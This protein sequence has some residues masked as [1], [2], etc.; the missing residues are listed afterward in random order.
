MTKILSYKYINLLGRILIGIFAI[1]I[2]VV[3]LQ[4]ELI[5]TVIENSLHVQFELLFFTFILLFLNWGIEAFKWSYAIRP[6]QKINFITAF[7]LTITGI[8]IGLITPNRLGEIPGRAILLNNKKKLKDLV[9]KTSVGSFSQL[10]VTFLFGTIATF[11]TLHFFQF[12]ISSNYVYAF[13]IVFTLLLL[14]A[15][16]YNQTIKKILYRIPFFKRTKL[17]KAL[18]S[19]TFNELV[20]IL[21]LSS[22]RYIVFAIQYYFVLLALGIEFRTFSELLLIPFCF[23]ITSTI[24]TILISEIGVRGSVALFVFGAISDHT[25]SI[26]TASILLWLINIA[27]PALF[28]LFFIN[29]L[30]IVGEG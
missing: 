19:F 27:L 17:L 23:L 2:I 14:L 7:K 25:L 18:D 16:F 29:R 6:I 22:I 9:V 28:G 1:W 8:T 21:L 3:K 13:L 20:V 10:I 26:L 5:N 15:Y 24:P 12:P 11:F 30:K 4:D